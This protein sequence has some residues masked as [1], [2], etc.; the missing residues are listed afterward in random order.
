MVIDCI[1]PKQHIIEAYDSLKENDATE[2]LQAAYNWIHDECY[3]QGVAEWDDDWMLYQNRPGIPL[4]GAT[5]D[6]CVFMS[7]FTFYIDQGLNVRDIDSEKLSLYGWKR[8]FAILYQY[9]KKQ[10]CLKFKGSVDEP[11]QMEASIQPT[12]PKIVSFCQE[13]YELN[14]LLHKCTNKPVVKDCP[15]NKNIIDPLGPIWQL[16]NQCAA[17]HQC[18]HHGKFISRSHHCI[19]CGFSCHPS[20]LNIIQKYLP[21]TEKSQLKNWNINCVCLA[22]LNSNTVLGKSLIT[23]ESGT[24]LIQFDGH[25]EKLNEF[26]WASLCLIDNQFHS[27]NKQKIKSITGI[28]KSNVLSMEEGYYLFLAKLLESLGKNPL[29]STQ[30]TQETEKQEKPKETGKSKSDVPGKAGAKND[31]SKTS[32]SSQTGQ[33]DQKKKRKRGRTQL[34]L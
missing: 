5:Y 30:T 28:V 9:W 24:K 13:H 29:P 21:G 20:C 3:D 19:A 26:S 17:G 11:I 1:F 25:I 2:A 6:C 22:C 15:T 12:S 8:M 14:Q 18:Q 23:D 32:A 4:Q 34:T 33:S 16:I 7:A 10:H 31:Q 27:Y